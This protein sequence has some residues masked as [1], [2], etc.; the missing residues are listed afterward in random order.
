M[1]VAYLMEMGGPLWSPWT[2]AALIGLATVLLWLAF[3]PSRPVRTV[4]HR[5]GRYLE[6]QDVVQEDEMRRP[7]VRR[8]L[9]PLLRRMLRLLGL[10]TPKRSLESTRQLLLHAGH[11]GG[12]SALDF[13]GLRLLVG[14]LAGGG[15]A[16]LLGRRAPLGMALY[17]A[18]IAGG[19]GFFLPLFWLRSRVRSRRRQI[20]RALPDALDML[21]ISAEAGLAFESALVRVGEQWDNPLTREFLRTVGEMRVGTPRDVALQRMAERAGVQELSTFVTVLIQSSQLGVSIAQVLHTQAAQMRIQRR[22]RA[23]ELARQAGVKMVIPLALLIFPAML[24]VILGP[25]IPAFLAVFSG[26]GGRA[27]FVR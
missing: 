4:H 2:F 5:L 16:L 27:V 19:M 15:F 18:L 7:F 24:V 8:V 21:T 13:L 10:L 14:I 6:G 23:E 17:Y 26:P 25:S 3:A 12:L 20:L 22:Q 9:V 1:E 11:P